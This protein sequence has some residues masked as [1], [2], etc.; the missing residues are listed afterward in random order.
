MTP[1]SLA[2]LPFLRQS[3][4]LTNQTDAMVFSATADPPPTPGSI[5]S[6]SRLTDVHSKLMSDRTQEDPFQYYKVL[7]VLGEGS[8]VRFADITDVALTPHM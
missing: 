7:S 2:S 5:E 3:S 1:E 4:Q 6:S 8:M